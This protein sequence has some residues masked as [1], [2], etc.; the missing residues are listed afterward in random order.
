MVSAVTEKANL[1]KIWA[2]LQP[3]QCP[4]RKKS[5][6]RAAMGM[7][8][9]FGAPRQQHLREQAAGCRQGAWTGTYMVPAGFWCSHHICLANTAFLKTRITLGLV[10]CSETFRLTFR[11]CWWSNFHFSF[12]ATEMKSKAELIPHHAAFHHCCESNAHLCTRHAQHFLGNNRQQLGV[13]QAPFS[14]NSSGCMTWVNST[15]SFPSSAVLG[16]WI[17]NQLLLFQDIS[18]FRHLLFS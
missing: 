1:L 5:C 2:V 14:P 10:F 12:S 13:S 8:G 18:E 4:Q 11:Y 6:W 3:G 9:A 16:S 15:Q 7:R 17:V